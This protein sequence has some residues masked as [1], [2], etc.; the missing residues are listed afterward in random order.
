MGRS[1]R[2]SSAVARSTSPT[3]RCRR[4]ETHLPPMSAPI[5]RLALMQG[6]THVSWDL[7]FVGWLGGWEQDLWIRGW[8][9]LG[10]FLFDGGF[11]LVVSFGEEGRCLGGSGVPYSKTSILRTRRRPRPEGGTD[12]SHWRRVRRDGRGRPKRP[13]YAPAA[14]IASTSVRTGWP[15]VL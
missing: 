10:A 6:R 8:T 1:R 7:G 4:G 14:W 5:D 12:K 11:A 13:G 9:G 2:P 3:A 15:R